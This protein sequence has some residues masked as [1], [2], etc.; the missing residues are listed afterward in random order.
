MSAPAKTSDNVIK[1]AARKIL[2]AEGLENLSMQ[3]VAEAVGIRAPSLY[4]HFASR[5]DLL[6]ALTGDAL[7]DLKQAVDKS[8]RPGSHHSKLQ[9]MANA[10][11]TFAK[12]NP[13]A[14]NLIF[15]TEAA[16]EEADLRARMMS[17][18]TLLNILSEAI[19]PDKALLGARTLVAFLHGFIVMETGGLFRFGGDVNAAFNFGLNA[20]LEALLKNTQP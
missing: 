3:T 2:E 16:Q 12:R 14:Y 18:A 4:K 9:R 11:R 5:A 8:V 13:G 1:S 15:N 17:A 10:Y 7:Q 20:I 6:K 19:G